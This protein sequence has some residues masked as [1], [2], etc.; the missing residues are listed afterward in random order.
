VVVSVFVAQ[1]EVLPHVKDALSPHA[2]IAFG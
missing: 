1:V 2:R